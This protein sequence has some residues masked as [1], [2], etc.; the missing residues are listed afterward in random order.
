MEG[1]TALNSDSAIA[2][3]VQTMRASADDGLSDH[4]REEPSL[5]AD[6][7]AGVCAFVQSFQGLVNHWVGYLVLVNQDFDD[8]GQRV[9]RSAAV[10]VDNI[11][12]VVRVLEVLF[13]R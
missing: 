4:G 1:L 8:A 13:K 11:A 5:G 12:E 6:G 10:R 7:N 3:D 2:A 9:S